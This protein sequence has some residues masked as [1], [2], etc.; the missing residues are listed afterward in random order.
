MSVASAHVHRQARRQPGG[1][2]NL[3]LSP[4][5]IEPAR[6]NSGKRS[7]GMSSAASSGTAH[8]PWA[9][10]SIWLI[11]ADDGSL[12]LAPESWKT[13]QSWSCR[14]VVVDDHA[15]GQFWRAHSSLGRPNSGAG[16]WPVSS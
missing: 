1:M 6:R 10:S 16:Q 14:T 2:S 3:T 15:P 7:T 8:V 12:T 4:P 5:A 9:T 13:N 11:A